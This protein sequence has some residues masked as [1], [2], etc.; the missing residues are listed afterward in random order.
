MPPKISIIVPVF[1]A[2]AYLAGC[3]DSILAQT[4]Q[5]FE[6]ILVDDGSP[7]NSGRICEEYAAKDSRI[8][9]IHK[10]NGILFS[11]FVCVCWGGV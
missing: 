9:V 3:L 5:D 6:L 8:H 2:E 1:K 7:D 11:D 4:F 10:Q